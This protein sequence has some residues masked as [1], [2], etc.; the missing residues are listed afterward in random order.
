MTIENYDPESG[1]M[2]FTNFTRWYHWGAPASTAGEY[3]GV[4]MRGEVILMSRNVRVVG[5]DNDAWGAQIV[6]SDTIELSGVQ[7]SGHVI[8]DNVECYNCS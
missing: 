2:T 3:S 6:V 4:D 8:L 1:I 7:R 5:E